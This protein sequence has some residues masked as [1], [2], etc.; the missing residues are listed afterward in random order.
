MR[1]AR[2]SIQIGLTRAVQVGVLAGVATL[3]AGVMAAPSALAA[4]AAPQ[5]AKLPST[6]V[7]PR[8]YV[9]PMKGQMGTDVS[10]Q[11]VDIMVKD[12]QKQKPDIIVYHLNS[13]DIDRNNYLRN[14]DREEFGMPA[15]EEYRDIVK[16][17]HE[18]LRDIPQIMWVEDS[19]G[20]AS[21][22]ALGWP[23]LYMKSDAR[24]WGLSRVASGAQVWEDA[25]IKSK[26]ETAA[27]GIGKGIL[28]QGG[29]NLVLGD[30]MMFPDKQ[31]S[32]RFKGREVEWLENTNGVWIVDGSGDA[33]ANFDATL[34]EDVLL[35]DGTADTLD[36]LMFLLGYREFTQI[37]SGPKLAEQYVN[38]WR[39]AFERVQDWLTDLTQI[40]DPGTVGLG[41]RRAVLE[42]MLA[43]LKQY[44]AIEAR[45]GRR[46]INQ[47]AIEIEIDDIKK[48]IQRIREAER[49]SRGGDGGGGSGRPGLGGGGMGGR[50]GS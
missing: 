36:D 20:F 9:F 33:T 14:D 23:D 2:H 6:L 27:T 40:D 31:L 37:E 5:N 24:L 19:V 50:R 1:H 26:M 8:V 49:G 15:I 16:R 48:E 28:Q 18:D 12:I 45:L 11:L 44:P 25:D 41:K 35:S 43:A 34:A 47:T 13:A 22:V 29:Y 4:P 17:L 10:K 39:K 46:G 3:V 30:A 38:D 42:K 32:V 7:S 21:L